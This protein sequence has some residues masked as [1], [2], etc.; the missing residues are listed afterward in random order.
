MSAFQALPAQTPAPTK[1]YWRKLALVVMATVI[2]TVLLTSQIASVTQAGNNGSQHISNRNIDPSHIIEPR[3]QDAVSGAI[4]LNPSGY[5]LTGFNVPEDAQ[6]AVLQGN[7]VLTDN[8]TNNAPTVTVWSQQEFINY[9]S[10]Q[11][12]VPCY[13]KDFMP[14]QSDNINITLSS[15]NYLILISNAGLDAKILQA[16]I[17]LTYI[18]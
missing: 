11:N 18:N 12:A 9:F 2:I 15:G 8:S 14:M 3:T 5:Y 1:E 13:N 17:E 10:C 4:V 6:N 7:Y 16:Q